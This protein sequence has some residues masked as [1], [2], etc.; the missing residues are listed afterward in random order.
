M[1]PS[2][3]GARFLK[4]ETWVRKSAACDEAGTVKLPRLPNGCPF[5]LNRSSDTTISDWD[6]FEMD[7]PVSTDD[8]E[9]DKPEYST[10]VRNA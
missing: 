3:P 8:A 5:R 1:I 10:Y 4:A 6:G 2:K 7:K 9:P